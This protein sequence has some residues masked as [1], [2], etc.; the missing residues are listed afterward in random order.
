VVSAAIN[1]FLVSVVNPSQGSPVLIRFL[2]RVAVVTI[3]SGLVVR[4]GLVQA[5][6]VV[7]LLLFQLA[8]FQIKPELGSETHFGRDCE[9]HARSKGS[10]HVY[11][12]FGFTSD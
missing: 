7:V 11:S 4:I 3:R 5:G 2:N 6:E 1:R 12:S 10:L 9:K 8:L